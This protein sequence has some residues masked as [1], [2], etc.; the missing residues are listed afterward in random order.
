[1]NFPDFIR[2]HNQAGDPALYDIENEA[3]DREGVLWAALR[4]QAPWQGK[5]L[6][7]LGCGSG[8]WLSRYSGAATVIGVEP[9]PALV[10]LAEQRAGGARVLPGAA[11]HTPLED[12]SVDVVHARFA[13]FFPHPRFDPT[14]GLTEVGRVLKPGGS[15][16]VVDNDTEAGEFADLLRASSWA[17]A[18][19]ADTE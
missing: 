16:V 8:F 17:A 11:E 19:G 5:V 2:A 12:A 4:A 18:Q 13:Y 10:S 14:A 7:D 15:L 6:V 1:M 3:I 9:D